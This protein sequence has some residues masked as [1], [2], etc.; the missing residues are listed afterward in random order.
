MS[1][2]GSGNNSPR[3]EAPTQQPKGKKETSYTYWVKNDPNYYK[4]SG[5][6]IKPKKVDEAEV[7]K[8][9]Q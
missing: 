6:D 2:T 4:E 9:K 5:I 3:E 1:D 8:I 7:Q